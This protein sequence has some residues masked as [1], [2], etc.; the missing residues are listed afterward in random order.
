MRKWIQSTVF[1]FWDTDRIR[2]GVYLYLPP[3]QVFYWYIVIK[4]HNTVIIILPFSSDPYL[5]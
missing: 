5:S 3:Q 1:H 4:L 2:K